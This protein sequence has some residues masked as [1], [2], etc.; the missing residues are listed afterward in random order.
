M[1][2]IEIALKVSSSLCKLM[3]SDLL[4][5]NMVEELVEVFVSQI[6]VKLS[7]VRLNNVALSRRWTVSQG[8][9]LR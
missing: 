6:V 1:F 8:I 3:L 9:W 4:I 7:T 2:M 5:E